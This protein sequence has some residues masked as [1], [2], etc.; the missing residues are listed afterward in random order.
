MEDYRGKGKATAPLLPMLAIPTT[1]GTG[2]ENQSFA[3]I[4][5]PD[6]HQKMACGDKKALPRAAILDPEL[7]LTCPRSVTAAAGMDAIS[8]AVEAFVTAARTPV[9]DLL[10]RHAW[11][12]LSTSFEKVL[13]EP[14]DIE[15]RAG[16]LLGASLAGAAIENS[17]LGAAHAAANPLTAHSGMVHGQAVCVMLPHIV[18]FNSS[19]VGEDYRELLAL[20][21]RF[22]GPAEDPG[23]VL[24]RW[25]ERAL[26]AAGF[27]LRLGEAGVRAEDCAGLARAAAEQW[28][29]RFNPK[30]ISEGDFLEIYRRAL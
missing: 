3:L 5:E 15:A 9:S 22:P 7:T 14:L 16:M 10:A 29:A 28:T 27:P 13:R 2:S 1:A 20:A 26:R 19:T 12:L 24:A 17:M 6:S 11:Q 21:N 25:I 30:P 18:R 4:S 8:H 23:D